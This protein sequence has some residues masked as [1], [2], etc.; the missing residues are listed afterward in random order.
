MTDNPFPV[1]LAQET[2]QKIG[3]LTTA[4]ND[5]AKV[6]LAAKLASGRVAE[7]E[8]RLTTVRAETEAAQQERAGIAA[9]S[10]LERGRLFDVIAAEA[11]QERVRLARAIEGERLA[12]ER[13]EEQRRGLEGS[14]ATLR[15]QVVEAR[16]AASVELAEILGTTEAERRGLK[17]Q[18]A[19]ART[20]LTSLTERVEAK[21]QE[22]QALLKQAQAVIRA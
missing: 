8:A 2:A 5:A 20:Q 16:E 1:R 21:R 15:Q 3:Q 17:A 4:L 6:L 9:E 13:L 19:E 10:E 11:E 7:A 12:V 18:V 22:Y 14:M